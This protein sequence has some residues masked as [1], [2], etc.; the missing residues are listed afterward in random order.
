MER[1]PRSECCRTVESLPSP[2]GR[3]SSWPSSSQPRVVFLVAVAVVIVAVVVAPSP[4]KYFTTPPPGVREVGVLALPRESEKPCVVTP[5]RSDLPPHPVDIS[6]FSP[7]GL[8][9]TKILSC[10]DDPTVDDCPE[11]RR[12]D[13]LL[14]LPEGLLPGGNDEIVVFR[15]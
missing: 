4:R 13:N 11:R 8:E 6:S 3:F 7:P 9:S 1:R 15:S 14:L 10:V 12:G 5:C 2:G